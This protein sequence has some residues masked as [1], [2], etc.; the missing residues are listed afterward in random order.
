[1]ESSAVASHSSMEDVASGQEREVLRESEWMIG[2]GLYESGFL[3]RM[4]V[5]V[6]WRLVGAGELLMERKVWGVPEMVS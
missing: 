4:F 5:R 2:M 3:A 1:M 6:E